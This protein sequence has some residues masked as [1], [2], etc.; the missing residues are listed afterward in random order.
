MS[1]DCFIPRVFN[2]IRCDREKKKAGQEGVQNHL[3][4]EKKRMSASIVLHLKQYEIQCS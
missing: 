1:S 2:D 3:L 4:W